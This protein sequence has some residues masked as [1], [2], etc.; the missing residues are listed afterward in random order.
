MQCFFQFFSSDFLLQRCFLSQIKLTSFVRSLPSNRE[1]YFVLAGLD[2]LWSC[3]ETHYNG[4]N[5]IVFKAM[6]IHVTCKPRDLIWKGSKCYWIKKQNNY[7]FSPWNAVEQLLRAPLVSVKATLYQV[8]LVTT[9]NRH[10]K[11]CTS[12]VFTPKVQR[13]AQG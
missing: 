4:C 2:L 5:R 3:C 6:S 13:N 8:G 12:T 11:L 10:K 1:S 7:T 9:L